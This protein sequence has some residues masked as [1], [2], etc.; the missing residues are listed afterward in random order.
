MIRVSCYQ[1]FNLNS[2]CTDSKDPFILTNNISDEELNNS[3]L[4]HIKPANEPLYMHF[5]QQEKVNLGRFNLT[6]TRRWQRLP[7][8]SRAKK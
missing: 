2:Y 4:L 3:T 6:L 8:V 1:Q 7:S 5:Q